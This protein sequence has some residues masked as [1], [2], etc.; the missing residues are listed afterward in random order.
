MKA[1]SEA[2]GRLHRRQA[3]LAGEGG[4]AFE[5]GAERVGCSVSQAFAASLALSP[6]SRI[7]PIISFSIST[8]KTRF[9]KNCA[10]FGHSAAQPV[11]ARVK[12]VAPP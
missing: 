6:S 1:V 10:A 8:V 5:P 3:G 4:D 2:E 12:T 11:R 7:L 9:L